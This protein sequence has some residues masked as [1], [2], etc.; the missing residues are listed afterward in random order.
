M[1]KCHA[2]VTGSG[3][4]VGIN[5]TVST[6]TVF[7]KINLPSGSVFVLDPDYT[8]GDSAIHDISFIQWD[9]IEADIE[10]T[11]TFIMADASEKTVEYND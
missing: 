8:I 11:L 6:G 10:V 2:F 3:V 1:P 4:S 5:V 9:D 7:S